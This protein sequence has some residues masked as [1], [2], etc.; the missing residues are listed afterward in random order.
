MSDR[1]DLGTTSGTTSNQ[2]LDEVV[3]VPVGGADDGTGTGSIST[4]REPA[5]SRNHLGNGNHLKP[6]RDSWCTPKWIA[7]AIGRWDLDPCANERSH[8]RA[9][10][11]FSL[12]AGQDGLAL[13]SAVDATQ[14]VWLNPPYSR[15]QVE[16][17]VR[18]Y[19]HTRFCFLLRFDPSTAWFPLVYAASELVA[20]PVGR[21]VNFEPPPGVKASSNP[22]PH[23]LF[24]RRAE[25]AT[26]AIRALCIAWR[27][28]PT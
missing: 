2:V 7:D 21:R 23:V 24:F 8:V 26:P 1:S 5:G 9:G 19:A 25:D 16:R 6:D 13:A 17:W 14:R 28:R 22:Y 11:T 15:G 20:V 4:G 18:A 27:R 3:P 10:R 12:A